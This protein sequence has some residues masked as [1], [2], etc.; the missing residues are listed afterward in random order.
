MSVEISYVNKRGKR[1]PLQITVHARRRMLQR[2]PRIHPEQPISMD[3]VDERIAKLFAA[4]NRVQ[5]LSYKE[6][7]R[8][9]RHG[10]D[11]LL[12]RHDVF[13]FVVQDAAIVTIEIS[14]KDKRHLNNRPEF[15][16]PPEPALKNA[17]VP[18][19]TG[20][21]SVA[22][23]AASAP[24]DEP[25]PLPKFRVFATAEEEDGRMHSIGLG[26]YD[27]EAVEGDPLLLREDAAFRAVVIERYR[28]KARTWTPIGIFVRLGAKGD[29]HTVFEGHELP[30]L[31]ETTTPSE[32]S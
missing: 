5:N 23:A 8:S 12:F 32:P 14:A 29:F 18:R 1:V 28:A 3:T 24:D 10:K 4:A 27:S 20:S 15:P 13:T 26:S 31:N 19:A 9:N 11:T 22:P 25:K 21:T 16:P 2:W 30:E 6:T 17:P 7:I